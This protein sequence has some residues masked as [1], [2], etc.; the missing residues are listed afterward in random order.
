[1]QYRARRDLL[2]QKENHPDVSAARRAMFADAH[3]K[4]VLKQLE[5]WDSTVISSHKSAGHPLHQLAFLA[6]LGLRADDPGMNRVI[7]RILKHQ[8]SEGAF[9][10]LMN[11]PAHFG[12][13]GKDT[14]AWALCDTPTIT[15]AL[16]QFGMGN[17]RIC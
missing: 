4:G 1:M 16:V 9:Q 6:D 14:W 3:V 13:T 12:G 15:Y 2:K 8:S 10:V 7:A 17:D 11:V 5:K